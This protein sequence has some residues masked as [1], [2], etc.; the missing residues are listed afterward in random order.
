MERY[1]P[2]AVTVVAW[3]LLACICALATVNSRRF[4]A[5][6]AFVVLLVSL[7]SL[8]THKRPRIVLAMVVVFFLAC[9][10]P[11]DVRFDETLA[12]NPRIMPIIWG[13]PTTKTREAI[14][15]GQVW[16]GGC[17]VGVGPMA[18][19]VLVL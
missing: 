17:I 2:T 1:K 8:P 11:I 16:G 6:G 4:I 19:W 9:L 13:L 5:C 18:R 15:N 12:F 7:L 10:S 3:L 14:N